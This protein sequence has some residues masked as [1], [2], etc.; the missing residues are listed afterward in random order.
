MAKDYYKI[1]GVEK[2]ATQDDIKKA[3]RKLAHQYHPDKAGGDEAKFKEANEAYQVLSDEKKRAQY[4]QFG[5]SAFDGSA[6]F[7]GGQGFGGFDFSGFKGG[8]GFE[9][10]GDIFGEMFGG[11]SRTRERRGSDIQVDLDLTFKESIFGAQKDIDLTKVD[12]CERC[13]GTGGEPAEAMETCKTCDGN[14][15]VIGVQRTILGNVQTKRMCET[16]QGVG[17]VPKKSCATCR[18]EGVERRKQKLTVSIP[19]GVE[20][21]AML[22]VRGGGEAIKA[23]SAGDLFVRLHIPRD[24][25]FERDGATLI[26][27]S[28]IGFTQAALG[29]TIEVE[30]VDGVVDLKIPPGTQSGSQFRLRGKGVPHG[31]GRGDQIIVVNIETPTKLSREQK[32]L[33][34]EL[35]LK[36]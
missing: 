18:G 5:S 16:C 11:R 12:T 26:S 31:R 7:G 8:A 3:F 25:R 4:D 14:G 23:G 15:V 24:A 20:N 32:K 30:T 33:L 9:D 35:D 28:R 13:S 1:L 29:D 36:E 6:G 27:R 19:P 10:L 17:K 2:N 22:R 34:E 21:G